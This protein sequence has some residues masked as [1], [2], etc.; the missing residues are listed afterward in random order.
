MRVLL[1]EDEAK[2]AQATQRRLAAEGIDVELSYDGVDGLWRATEGSYDVVVLDILMP[3]MNGYRVCEELRARSVTTPILMLTAKSG[4]YDEAEGLET[5][6]DDYLTKPFSF[7]VLIAR[8]H[9]LASRQDSIPPRQSARPE[10]LH[11]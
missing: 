11:L 6:A 1:V 8:L 9:A 4:E 2:L 7:V 10:W 3:G 5:G